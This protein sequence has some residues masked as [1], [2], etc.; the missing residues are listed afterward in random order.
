MSEIVLSVKS[1]QRKERGNLLVCLNTN[2]FSGGMPMS[3][4]DSIGAIGG[5][6]SGGKCN[7][8]D[9]LKRM[10]ENRDKLTAQKGQESN[11]E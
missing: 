9:I 3:K 11:T 8:A 4:D 10:Q 2:Y 6:K 1:C 5:V 7:H